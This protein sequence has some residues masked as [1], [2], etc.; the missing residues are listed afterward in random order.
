MVLSPRRV[1]AE[2]QAANPL[3]SGAL[4]AFEAQGRR[5]FDERLAEITPGPIAVPRSGRGLGALSSLG[6]LPSPESRQED[7]AQLLGQKAQE[8]LQAGVPRQRVILQ[9]LRTPEGIN[10]LVQAPQAF[11][12]IAS[13]ISSAD[14]TRLAV[15]SGTTIFEEQP[16]GGFEPVARGTEQRTANERL[17]DAIIRAE[18]SGTPEDKRRSELLLTQLKSRDVTSADAIRLRAAGVKDTGIPTINKVSVEE[19][20]KASAL[21]RTST[22]RNIDPIQLG[23]RAAGQKT[24][25]PRLDALSP[26]VAEGVFVARAAGQQNFMQQLLGTF[27]AKSGSGLPGA[28][29]ADP[30]SIFKALRGEKT[31]AP[32][33]PVAPPIAGAPAPQPPQPPPVTPQSGTAPPTPRPRPQPVE[34]T[35][36]QVSQTMSDEE[37]QELALQILQARQSGQ[38]LELP[39]GV[40]DALK[41][42]LLSIKNRQ[43]TPQIGQPSA[44]PQV[45]QPPASGAPVVPQQQELFPPGGG[46]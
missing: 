13:L 41:G 19:A 10:A 7:A 4:S 16:G 32:A 43:A 42:R 24:G 8:L 33:A 18:N 36:E 15:G 3:F 26:E 6:I 30:R 17:V 46:A 35:P 11:Q 45:G 2:A 34:V 37:V 12:N 27:A 31:D 21:M 14:P 38:P 9:L 40:A 20:R 5:D 29:P 28:A 22:L 23:I 25:D 39:P 1:T 44:A